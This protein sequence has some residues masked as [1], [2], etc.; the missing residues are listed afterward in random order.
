MKLTSWLQ[1]K[2][3]LFKR[4]DKG[5]TNIGIAL[6]GGS[7]RGLA[8]IGVLKALHENNI[9][10]QIISGTSMGA[11][12]GV[13]YASGLRPEEIQEIVN[14]EPIVKMVR[15]AWNQNGLFKMNKIR[16]L[17]EKHLEK[18]D[19]SVLKKP[20]Y[21]SVS[22]INK[23]ENEVISEGALFDYILAS[24]AV[25]V[26]FAPQV[27]NKNTYIDGGLFNNL[28]AGAIRNKCKSLIGVHVNYIGTV[29]TFEGITSVAERV[30][31]LAIGENVK[32]S[33]KMCDILIEPSELHDFSFWD[34]N[35]ADKIIKVGYDFTLDIIKQG[36]L[37]AI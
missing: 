1:N 21:L 17:L 4:S 8:H 15:P 20:F 26:I 24:C 12:V 2:V 32:K 13:L 11:L 25:P 16:E 28:P 18:D 19:F 30:F 3:P 31:S 7:A 9:E 10:P 36:K 29:D 5:K 34:Y 6:S 37:I 22:N 23:G 35:K 27:I 14:K 33:M